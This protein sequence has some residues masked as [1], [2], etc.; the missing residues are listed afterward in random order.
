MLPFLNSTNRGTGKQVVE[1]RGINYSDQTRDGDLRD[2]LNLSARRYPFLSTRKGREQ[3]TGYSGCTALMAR[4]KLIAVRGT[5]LLYD[6]AVVG[7]VTTGEKQFAVVNTRIVIWPDKVYLDL[8]SMAVKNLGASASGTGATFTATTMTVSGWPDLTKLF[9]VGDTLTVSGCTVTSNNKDVTITGVTAT[10]I[11]VEEDDFA[12]GKETGAMSLERKIPDMDFICESENRLWGCSSEAQTI[13]ASALGDPTNFF[14]YSGVDTDSW[15]V[16]VGSEGEFTGC[17]KLASSVLFWKETKLHKVLGSY[18]SEYSVYSYDIEGLQKGCHKSMQIINEVLYYMGLH[19]VYSFSGNIPSLISA[20]F[21]DRMMSDAVGGNDGDSYYL[22]ALEGETKHLMV[23]ETRTGIWLR[24]DDTR[25]VDF[26]RIGKN[27]YLLDSNG[28]VWL[29]D[30]RADDMEQNWM[31]QFTPFYETIQGRKLYSKLLLR[32]ELPK[33]AWMRAEV[34]FDDGKWHE[35]GKILGRER[36]SIPLQIPINR[37]DRFELRLSGCGPCSI[38]AM[39]IEYQVG[40][41]V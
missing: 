37:C 19:G 29:A 28:N 30:N 13:Y 21:G 33:G 24:E 23:Y 40:S 22:S 27:L 39:A 11:T 31:A 35:V 7:Q 38:L 32:L 26:A 5:D 2:C 3:Q 14:T 6:G 34:C 12:A 20:N 10:S 17:C 4:G 41:D 1:F 36:D 18:P 8:T 15:A 25:V 9:V 16:P